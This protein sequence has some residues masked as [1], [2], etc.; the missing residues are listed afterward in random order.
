MGSSDTVVQWPVPQSCESD[1]TLGTFCV[2]LAC[3]ESAG[4]S[5]G[6]SASFYT[7]E[8]CTWGEAKSNSGPRYRVNG[9]FFLLCDPVIK[10]PLV[11]GVT[12]PSPYDSMENLQD[13]ECRKK[14]VLKIDGWMLGLSHHHLKLSRFLATSSVVSHP[15]P[16]PPLCH[17]FFFWRGVRGVGVKLA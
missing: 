14:R 10:W 9:W 15:P 4:F 11:R 8:T 17:D 7:P 12:L 3:S 1:S 16:P 6:S 5:P 13:P 2:E